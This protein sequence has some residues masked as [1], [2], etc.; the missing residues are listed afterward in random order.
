MNSKPFKTLNQQLTI[1]RNRG[2]NVPTKSKRSLEQIGYYALINGYKWSFLQ[3][4]SSGHVIHSEHYISGATF[5][6]IRSLYDFD[7][8]LRAI[9]YRSLLKYEASLGAE[10]S[11]KFSEAH[12]EEHSYLAI[13]NFQRNP[14]WTGS[15]VGTIS[16][17]SREIQNKLKGDDDNAVKHYVNKHGHVPLWVLVNFLTFGE[18]NYFYS[19]M[20]T[21]LQLEV[22]KDFTRMRVREYRP[23][24]YVPTSP[25]AIRSV[26]KIVNL[27]RNSVAHGEITFSK[28]LVKSTNMKPIKQALGITNIALNSQ[29]GLFELILCMKLMLTKKDYHRLQKDLK[30]LFSN[31][32]NEFTSI[33]FNS[34]LQDMNFPKRYFDYI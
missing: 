15:V 17:L 1:L 4:D 29:A 28:K 11:Y 24:H 32:K 8:E 23:T 10:L 20:T 26:N 18:L 34:V 25:A 12:P 2:L 6:E 7:A 9:L 13:D 27:F 21:D 5:A 30:G 31:Y 22:A 33:S 16:A 14:D 3:R 19:N